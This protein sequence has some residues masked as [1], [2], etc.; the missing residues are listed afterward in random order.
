MN[1][2]VVES[3][4]SLVLESMNSS[5]FDEFHCF[6]VTLLLNFSDVILCSDSPEY[7]YV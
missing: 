2:L 5:I 3:M 4:N 6:A 7:I 1:S